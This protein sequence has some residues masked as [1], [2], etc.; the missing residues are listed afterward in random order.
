MKNGLKVLLLTGVLLLAGSAWPPIDAAGASTVV[1]RSDYQRGGYGSYH[2]PG[3]YYRPYA[4]HH[5]YRPGHYRPYPYRVHY[6]PPYRYWPYAYPY[7]YY[8]PPP[9]PIPYYPGW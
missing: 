9:P 4:G 3:A 7:Y 2:H 1:H 5:P 6:P 8:P